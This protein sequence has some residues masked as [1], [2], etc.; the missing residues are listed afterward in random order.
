MLDVDKFKIS[1]FENHGNDWMCNKWLPP[2]D[3]GI[4]I[5]CDKRHYL[6]D[7]VGTV[8]VIDKDMNLKKL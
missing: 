6:P 3:D 8:Q 5:K 1:G 7:G 2:V 4:T